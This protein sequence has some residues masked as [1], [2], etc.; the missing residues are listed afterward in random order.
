ME[1]EVFR[2]EDS[3]VVIIGANGLIGSAITSAAA[4]TLGGNILNRNRL[5]HQR[6][7]VH[8]ALSSI[9]RVGK[10]VNTT[11]FFCHGGKGFAMRDEEHH[12]EA[13]QFRETCEKLSDGK[14]WGIKKA[15]LVSSL[16]CYLSE[17]KTPYKD[18]TWQKEKIFQDQ[19]GGDSLIARIPSIY[20]R[21][22]KERTGLIGTLVTNTLKGE[23]TTIYGDL[24]T[25][26]NYIEA[27][28][29]G[30]ALVRWGMATNNESGRVHAPIAFCSSRSYSI[31]EIITI[32]GR[33]LGKQPLVAYRN[34]D[35]VNR[36]DHIVQGRSDHKR[37][38]VDSSIQAWITRERCR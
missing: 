25:R 5:T 10:N 18:L 30:R 32:M 15:I 6:E 16:G 17:E 34:G 20:G 28:A 8:D 23:I 36:E 27:Q 1:S 12:I 11:I 29:C 35:I 21:K 19:F 38:I 26:R 22:N 31:M 9:D 7:R 33:T 3:S 14:G 24:Q 37:V 13:R 4:K 2:T